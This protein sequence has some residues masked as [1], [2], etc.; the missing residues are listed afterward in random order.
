M[1]EPDG[2]LFVRS[3]RTIE[4]IVNAI[5]SLVSPELYT[6]GADAVRKLQSGQGLNQW[7]ESIL[8][9]NSVF[10]GMQVISNR[11]TPPHRDPKAA[12]TMYDILVSA[13]THKDAVLCLHD[14]DTKLHYAPCTVVAVCGRVLLHEVPDWGEGERIC[15]THYMRDAVHNRLGVPRPAWVSIQSYIVLM[16]PAFAG[17]FGVWLEELM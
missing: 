15:V 12:K 11:V 2:Q 16:D 9:W 17:R 10:S 6:L 5:M 1:L 7:R 4:S 8:E 13:G 14:I 3:I